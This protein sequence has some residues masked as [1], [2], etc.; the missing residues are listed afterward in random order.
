V[1][2]A[3][4][5]FG[6]GIW[7]PVASDKSITYKSVRISGRFKP[8]W[9]ILNL[10]KEIDGDVILASKPQFTSF[11]VGL[12]KKVFKR[13][14]L[15]LDIDDWEMGFIKERDKNTSS[16]SYLKA[17]MS[18]ALFFYKLNSF[19][20]NFICEKMIPF[21]DETIVSNTFLKNKFGGTIVWHARDTRAFDP[22]KF[23]KNQ[24]KDKYKIEA[25]KKIVMFF[26]SPKSH[27]GIEDLIKA[28]RMVES[29]DVI[30]AIVGIDGSNQY[31]KDLIKTAEESLNNKFQGFGLQPFE[32]IPEFLAMADIVVIPQKKNWGTEGQM[33]AKVFDAMAMAKPII[34]TAVSDLPEILAGCG[35]IVEP[36]NPEQLS[37]S[38]QYVI[39]NLGEAETV[40]NNA[41][42][43]CVEN[44]SFNK[45]EEKLVD[46]L[47]KYE[48]YVIP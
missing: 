12:F 39:E 19:W 23:H 30:L 13:K 36:E 47:R 1:E 26:G 25:K 44:Y 8:F 16:F 7:E 42:K 2:I 24:I 27:K 17:L 6:S 14:P 29:R 46:I 20:N 45:M 32:R 21:A 4:P 40:G 11:G 9:K 5:I 3:G 31:S 37:K 28:V 48:Q 22:A 41:R 15:I 35:W 43:K 18:S 34:A 10:V 33:P 38:I